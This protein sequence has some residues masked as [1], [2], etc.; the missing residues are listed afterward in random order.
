M[1]SRPLTSD[2]IEEFHGIFDLF[3]TNDDGLLSR[4]EL[5]DAMHS[6]GMTPTE[7]ELDAIFIKTDTDMSGF[8]EFSEFAKWVADKVDLTSQKDLLEIFSLIDVDGNGSISMDELRQLLDS[9]K[10]KMNEKD[11]I[12]LFKDADCDRSGTI[13]YK[14]FAKS[15]AT[16]TQIK[17][18]IGVTRSFKEI[19]KQYTQLAENPNAGFGVTTPLPYGRENAIAMGYDVSKFPEA[20][21]ESSCMCGNSFALGEIKQGETVI[22]LGCGSGADLCVAA[23]LVGETGRV[24]GVDMTAAMVR[25]A[26]K[27]AE[28]CGF[29]NI[30][31]IQAPFDMGSHENIPMGIADVV[32]A[33]GT[34]NLSPRKKCAFTQALSCLKPG[35]RFYMVDIVREGSTGTEM[36]SGS[37]CDC[38]AGA[39]T[40]SKMLELLKSAG[41]VFCRHVDFTPYRTSPATVAATFR[42]RKPE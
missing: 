37:W 5:A 32:I 1:T 25:Q 13:D 38:V 24:I 23:D 28:L 39:V 3:D 27:N 40:V 26:R 7:E 15:D 16:W 35:G 6:L 22:D 20:L 19:L 33:N 4:S 12:D 31:V 30:E 14:E 29:K 11:L 21:W 42:A 17:L 41:F 18:T 9:L 34:F 8:I 36:E 10:I 2:Q